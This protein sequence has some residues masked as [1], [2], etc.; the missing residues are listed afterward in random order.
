MEIRGSNNDSV[1][2]KENPPSPISK[3]KLQIV[4]GM[5]C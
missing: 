2:I 3:G 1:R 4:K 5:R